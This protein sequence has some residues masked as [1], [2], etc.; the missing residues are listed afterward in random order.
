MHGYAA[1]NG[2]ELYY[3]IHGSGPPLILLHG[4]LSTIEIDFAG[5]I[6][7]LARTRR[8]IAI[9]QQA[10]GHTADID[11]PLR[12]EHWAE[13][14]AALL[15]HLD[16][17][18]ADVLGYSSGSIVAFRLA[19]AH[20]ELVRKLVLC[21]FA[22]HR[23]GAHAGLFDGIEELQPEHLAGTPYEQAY[24]TVAPRPQDWPVLIEKIKDMD[25]VVEQWSPGDV[26]NLG[27]AVLLVYGDSDVVRPE[28]AV[29]LFRLVGG[30][31]MGDMVGLPASRLAVLPGTTHVSLVQRGEWIA[32]MIDEFL[33]T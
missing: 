26:E 28:H 30:G 27:K 31:V 9:E 33:T 12:T 13:D 3:E 22:Y 23:G 6:P 8:V 16:V 2:L 15:R 1:V 18:R 5:I 25:A 14:T 11:R 7:A 10:H 4:N 19:L 32:S 20:P 24:A 21:S 29:E 17:E